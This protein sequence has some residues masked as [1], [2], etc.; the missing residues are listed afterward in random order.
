LPVI[1]WF[2]CLADVPGSDYRSDPRVRRS[3]LPGHDS[4]PKRSVHTFEG[5]R[6]ESLTWPTTHGE[7]SASPASRRATEASAPRNES[8]EATLRRLY[9]ILELPGTTSDYHFAIQGWVD[10]LWKRRREEP[11]VLPE[12]ERLCWL[13]IRLIEARPAT[14]TYERDGTT[15][16]FRVLAFGYLI[17]LYE[18]EGYVAEALDV[19]E[20]AARFGDPAAAADLRER[21]AQIES[22]VR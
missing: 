1:E 12:I 9:E 13:D 14:I 8:T 22:E 6:H 20:R 11:S 16:H 5:K 21:R 18:R 15:T 10:A 3:S 7:T 17:Q 4:V 19:A 2:R